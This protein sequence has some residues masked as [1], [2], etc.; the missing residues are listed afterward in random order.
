MPDKRVRKELKSIYKVLYK[1]YGPQHWWPGDTP[2]EVIV[3]AVLTQN[4]AW[5]NV[6][7]TI[8][9]LKC[10]HVLKPFRLNSMPSK[11]LASLIRPSGYFN[12]KTRRLKNLLVLIRDHYRGSLKR[13]FADDPME[14]R[15]NLLGVNGIG[16]ETADSILLYAGG[17]PFFVV[18]AYTKRILIR[19]GLISNNADYQEVQSLFMENLPKD[20]SLYNEFHALIVKVGKEHCRKRKP[21]CSGC[22]LHSPHLSKEH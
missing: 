5:G 14:L 10:E 2:F 7:K 17:K 1:A 22:P 21:L 3:G 11:R 20:A 19:H 16:P 6:E 18:D 12:I 15:A 9:N 13:M 4:T 8:T